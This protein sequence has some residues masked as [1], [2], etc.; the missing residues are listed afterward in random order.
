MGWNYI[1]DFELE[2]SD[3]DKSN[4]TWKDKNPRAISKI[5]VEIPADDWLWLG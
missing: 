5:S 1:P 3:P 4:K 2:Y